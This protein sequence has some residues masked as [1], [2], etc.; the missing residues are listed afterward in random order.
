MSTVC[1]KVGL[2]EGNESQSEARF[3]LS[4]YTSS[5]VGMLSSLPLLIGKMRLS[6]SRSSPLLTIITT[7]FF[8]HLSGIENHH[9]FPLSRGNKLG[10]R[11]GW[12]HLQQVLKYSTYLCFLLT[13]IEHHLV[14]KTWA[15]ADFIPSPSRVVFSLFIHN[16]CSWTHACGLSSFGSRIWLYHVQNHFHWMKPKWWWKDRRKGNM[17]LTA[18]LS[19]QIPGVSSV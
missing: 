4:N 11:L 12:L 3:S 9:H 17:F 8:Q 16:S 1:K 7:T 15:W 14:R 19:W 6:G 13:R 5:I 10:R 18:I 2:Q